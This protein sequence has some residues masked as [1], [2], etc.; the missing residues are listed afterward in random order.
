M[1]E[2]LI[3]LVCSA[4]VLAAAAVVGQLVAL[5]LAVLAIAVVAA[6]LWRP[7]IG[8]GLLVGLSIS[9]A[10]SVLQ[11]QFGIPSLTELLMVIVIVSVLLETRREGEKPL[12][13][14][15]IALLLFGTYLAAQM[16][17]TL[18]AGDRAIAATTS[19]ATARDMVVA[20]VA[21]STVR[22][23]RDQLVMT[24]SVIATGL[25]LALVSVHQVATGNF[26]S[27]YLGFGQASIEQIFGT[28]D[29]WRVKGPL[30]DP[31][32]Y[33]Q[34][35]LVVFALGLERSLGD[36]RV[37][38]RLVALVATIAAAATIVFTH[39]RGGLVG[40]AGVLAVTVWLHRPSPRVL[41][42]GLVLLLGL[43]TFLPDGYV[44]RLAKS[45]TVLSGSDGAAG[46]A[47]PSIEGRSSEL[48]VGVQLFRDHP[49]GGIGAG[50]YETRYQEYARPIGLDP[51]REDREAHSLYAEIASETG[52]IGLATFGLLVA[53]VARS[54]RSA[55]RSPNTR[56]RA[57][58][59]GL[60]AG[61]V[62]YLVAAIFLHAAYQRTLWILLVLGFAVSR[63]SSGSSVRA[64][65]GECNG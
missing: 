51:R 18:W 52:L 62:G 26:Y 33:A 16:A 30:D 12:N 54:L 44:E 61:L 63:S 25:V 23:L 11:V 6:A 36:S 56:R 35:M 34:L 7:V 17:S 46:D 9:N 55:M 21:V 57:L 42:V 1:S 19:I 39:S 20:L 47:D 60:A 38:A 59:S 8:G 24:W 29:D 10:S 13:P 58:A 5:V 27:D 45:T 53:A 2:P 22:S 3:G 37:P 15:P 31:N 14:T 4:L 28:L 40:L 49:V 43:A 50:N 48:Q 65:R 32:Y 64:T 41:A